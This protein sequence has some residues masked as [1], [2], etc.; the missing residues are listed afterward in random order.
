MKG[1][2]LLRLRLIT[3]PVVALG[4][5][6]LLSACAGVAIPTTVN[7]GTPPVNGTPTTSSNGTPGTTSTQSPGT[8]QTQSVFEPGSIDFAGTVQSVNGQTITVKMPDG[9]LLNINIV[10]NAPSVG[11]IVKIL[12]MANPDGSFTAKKL[13]SGDSGDLNN[14]VKYTGVT[15]SAVGPD[16]IIH[17]NVGTH[18]F[19]FTIIPGTTDLKD[20]NSNPQSIQNNQSVTVEVQFNNGANPTVSKVSNPN[21]H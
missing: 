7:N 4:I 15:T 12:A 14:P 6:L 5:M 9:T 10:G 19:S 2:R 18:S 20:F 8:T 3:L 21:S 1:Y 11:Q 13:S 17:F 16:N